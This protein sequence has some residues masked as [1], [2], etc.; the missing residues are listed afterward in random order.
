MIAAAAILIVA[1]VLV[2]NHAQV[3]RFL[4]YAVCKVQAVVGGEGGGSCSLE[5]DQQDQE[6]QAPPADVP[7]SLDPD[8]DLVKALQSTEKGR[9]TLQWLFDNN[10]PIEFTDKAGAYWDGT[11]MVLGKG[12]D[13]PA[14]VVHETNHA[15]YTK[16][17]RHADVNKLDRAAYVKA[18]VDEEVDGTVQQI[19]AA[20][21]FRK[22]G[23]TLGDA[24]GEAAYNKAYAAAKA[25][26]GS[27]SE[28][29]Q[30][31]ADAVSDE[32]YSGRIVTSTTSEPY[33]DYYGNDWD[34]AH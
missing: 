23:F 7:P 5:G 27:E 29:K 26:G 25:N 16:D 34:N 31:G 28:A 18:A 21:E 20:Q 8:S 10:I 6:P 14:V 30:A 11:K 33:P 19:L 4:S 17:G 32:F 3:E 9:E 12:Y 2:A 1:V 22:K 15:K 13:D 24:P